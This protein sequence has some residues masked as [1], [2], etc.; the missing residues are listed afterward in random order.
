[1]Y[2][3]LL[4]GRRIASMRPRAA[5]LALAMAASPLAAAAHDYK[6]GSIEIGHPWSRA[7]PPGA[8]TGA[9]YLQLTNEGAAADRLVSAASPAAAE[10]QIHEMRVND[11]IMTMRQLPDGLA[12]PPG[13]TVTLEPSSYHLMLMGL[14]APLKAGERVPVTLRFERAGSVDVSLLVDQIGGAPAAPDHSAMGAMDGH[15]EHGGADPGGAQ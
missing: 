2:S 5:V 13:E 4:A 8:A 7:T 14:V 15:G 9:G 3:F 6:V 10:V 12:V 1:M 11:G